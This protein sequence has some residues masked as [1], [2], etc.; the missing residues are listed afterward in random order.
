MRVWNLLLACVVLVAGG[1]VAC[2]AAEPGVWRPGAPQVTPGMQTLRGYGQVT[3]ITTTYAAADAPEV[4]STRY[5]CANE[6]K[7][8]V[9]IGKLLADIGLSEGVT[10]VPLA[11]GGGTVPA[12]VTREGAALVGCREGAEA[13][14]CA[15][16]TAAVLA[17][18]LARNPGLA[19]GAVAA[20][21]YPMYLDYFDRWGWGFCSVGGLENYHDWMG[22][23]AKFDGKP[24]L[25]N[26]TEDLDFLGQHQFRYSGWMSSLE[27]D[28]SDGITYNVGTEWKFAEA[29]KRGLPMFFSY[30]YGVSGGAN[31]SA[32]RFPDLMEQPADFL[33]SGWHGYGLNT[34]SQPH[35]SWYSKDAQGYL[36]ANFQAMMRRYAD[37]PSTLGYMQPHG[38]LVH[39][40]WYDMHADYS[41]FAQ[42]SWR[43]TLQKRGLDLATVSRMYQRGSTPFADWEEVPVPEFA[44]FA[45]LPG[46]VQAL[47]GEWFY[48]H[49][50][51]DGK[52][53]DAAWWSRPEAERCQGVRER[54]WDGALD[55]ERWT[56]IRAPG[57]DAFYGIFPRQER[58]AATTWFR[59][60][61]VLTTA[62]VQS[63][64]LYLYWFPISAE[65]IHAG[66]HPRFHG[67]YL[68][69][70]KAGEI[71]SWGALDV[72]Q[73]VHV[74]ENQLAL[75]LQGAMWNGRI[76]LSTEAPQVFPYL[77]K[78]RNQLWMMWKEWL[79]DAKYD[80]WALILD[81]MRQVDP[82]R[83]I[84]L[85]ATLSFGTDRWIDLAVRYGGHSHFTGEGMWYFPWYKRYGFL[86]GIPGSS[87]MAGPID[88]LDQQFDAVRRVFL[89]GL[90]THESVFLAQSM[91]RNPKIRQWWLDHDP[92]L[93]RMG[94][95]DIDGAG[96]QVLIY[97]STGYQALYASRQP[98]PQLGQAAREVQTPWMWDL[99]RGTLQ[100][101]GH[102]S[103]YLDDGGVRDGKMYGY[104]VMLDCGNETVSEAAVADLTAWVKAGGTFVTLPFTGRNS[105][106]EADTWPIRALTG[107]EPAKLRQPGGQVTIATKQSV[108][109]ALA[110]KT[111]PDTG[112]AEYMKINHNLLSVELRPE[113][114]S[115]ILATFENGAPAIVRRPLGKGS[116]IV[117][118][119]AFWRDAEDQK[120]IWWSRPGEDAFIADL[121]AGI[122]LGGPPCATNDRLV[123]PQPYR[124][125]N[126]L[127]A[128]TVLVSWHEDADVDVQTTLRLP[129]RP[130]RLTSFGVDGIRQLP[131]TWQDGVATVTVR[132]PAREVKVLS[133]EVY[134][135]AEAVA[136][137]WNY[138][139]RLW[140][141]LDKPSVDLSPYTTG[142][143]RDPTIDLHDG[144]RFTNAD[145]GKTAWT[146][147]DFDDNAWQPGHLD[148]LNID[149]A[150]PGQSAW[151]RRTFTVPADWLS[152]G[153]DIY[154]VS[155]A[156]ACAP[157]LGRARL[158]LNGE[159]LHDVGDS[160][161]Y[162]FPIGSR[163]R[164]GRNVVAFQLQSTEANP[165]YIGFI[166]NVFL[167]HR[168]PA[169]RVIELTG[170]WTGHDAAGAPARITL[171]GTGTLF[172]PT[173]TITIPKAWEGRY[174]VRLCLDGARGSVLG[175]WVNDRQVRR[176]HHG[177]GRRC[178]IDI[179]SQLRFGAENTIRLASQDEGNWP[180]DGPG[181]PP[182]WEFDSIRLEL[183]PVIPAK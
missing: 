52:P 154:L 112:R 139:Q 177:F 3:T 17:A 19:A 98:Y 33:Q 77:G 82:N 160:T 168:V 159:L 140:H 134:T 44:T 72:S 114:G 117:L 105:L 55:A 136:H 91:T 21:P 178:D 40:E 22:W 94:T 110:G 108:F 183:F 93:K 102:S 10:A 81:G 129:R 7:A 120:G 88:N 45:G 164:K 24:G 116:V 27:M 153:G 12:L 26:P 146:S 11:V 165:T 42:D 13:R 97:R 38:E 59:R 84:R 100:A 25:K 121:L 35:L 133:A 119:S 90:N 151:V 104:P 66:D 174:Q 37:K 115:E 173:R 123:W 126:G 1:L 6:A 16:P 135:P 60:G 58:D 163:L 96:P 162:E 118:G 138:Q 170:E 92:L 169:E 69:G 127:E 18:F 54:W 46:Q 36:T 56:A 107:C 85:A 172:A 95:Y 53:A 132:M 150:K 74:G 161:Y 87:E 5:L 23:A 141:Q 2:G 9:V 61:F 175:A 83:M 166:G 106:Q 34:K 122:G 67:V 158:Y 28:C 111:F 143:W 4:T 63:K 29:V 70:R 131:F 171:P 30:S 65:A 180:N 80:G 14:I 155:G 99:G 179:T 79:I 8:G 137:W 89:A 152:Q 62:Q 75:H 48:R 125:N 142:R 176:H 147:P 50:S 43:A 157:Y 144:A 71:G 64:P 32:R 73:F 41:R 145:P 51:G 49:E 109:R 47:E 156:W 76:F 130:T 20:A 149:G 167:Y 101:I 128:V 78:E 182:S 15:A 113:A 86:Y 39:D 124:S 181:K 148:V 31:W 68:N 103:L 57:S